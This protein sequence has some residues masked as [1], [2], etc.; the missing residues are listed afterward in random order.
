MFFVL[1]MF[2]VYT[3]FTIF[4]VVIDQYLNPTK[5]TRAIFNRNQLMLTSTKKVQF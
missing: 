5:A 3:K 2:F 4:H 1:S